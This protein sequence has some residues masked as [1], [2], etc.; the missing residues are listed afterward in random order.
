MKNFL[1]AEIAA[2]YHITRLTT[3]EN[4]I[5]QYGLRC[6][7]FGRIFVC[8]TDDAGILYSI[9]IRQLL[10][11]EEAPNLVILRLTQKANKFRVREIAMDNQSNEITMPFQNIIF[12]ANIPPDN[13]E[14]LRPVDLSVDELAAIANPSDLRLPEQPEFQQALAMIY[15]EP[16]GRQYRIDGEENN[17]QWNFEKKHL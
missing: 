4:E 15:E 16:N 14:Y 7:Q 10:G 13:I 9:A 5:Q 2:F 12:R 6:D 1:A 17:Q 3:W 8:R 11:L